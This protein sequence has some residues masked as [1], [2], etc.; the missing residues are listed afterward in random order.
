MKNIEQGIIVLGM[1][2]SG[3]SI[4]SKCLY[5]MGVNLGDLD[6]K[7][8]VSN[9]EGHFEDTELLSIN[10]DI[11]GRSG[12]TW[13]S[14]PSQDM[15]DEQKAYIESRY[16]SYFKSKSGLWGVKEPRF[17]LLCKYSEEYTNNPLYVYC[18]RNED[19]VAKSINVRD[20]ICVTE[21]KKIKRHYDDVIEKFLVDKKYILVNYDELIDNPRKII[22]IISN[23]LGLT[24][25][26]SFHDHIGDEKVLT[27][28]KKKQLANQVVSI[29]INSI[30]QPRKIFRVSNI[31]TI[32]QV[33]RR[34]R[35]LL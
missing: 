15:L 13:Y 14:P 7:K 1:H 32:K 33:F 35:E 25:K 29:F 34:S 20:G 30:K 17:S 24:Y 3:T 11:L 12:G 26:S 27:K 9:V 22:S 8:Y 5:K 16:K 6:E 28:K 10:E 2:R 23:D 21:A 4:L 18:V 19:D 31:D